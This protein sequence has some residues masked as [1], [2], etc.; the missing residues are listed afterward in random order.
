[1]FTS[2]CSSG[3]WL[4]VGVVWPINSHSP[5]SEAVLLSF[6]MAPIKESL[7]YAWYNSRVPLTFDLGFELKKPKCN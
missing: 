7:K 5:E 4:E 6:S 3:L 2:A 1:M